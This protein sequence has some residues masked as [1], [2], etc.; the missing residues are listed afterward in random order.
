[1]R[2][3]GSGEVCSDYLSILAEETSREAVVATIG[4]WLHVQGR[5][6]WDALELQAIDAADPA[7]NELAQLLMSAGHPIHRRRHL[8]CWR[9]ELP[10][11]WE[12]YLATL[13]RTRRSMVRKLQRNCFDTG[14]AVVRCACTP[15]E[16]EQ[17]WRILVDLHQR[18]RR[19]L[20]EYGCFATPRF[21]QFLKVAMRRLFDRGLVRLQ[22]VELDGRPAVV[23]ID[24]IG[25]D[26]L[27]LYQSGIEPD[28]ANERPGWLGTMA[29]LRAGAEAG[30]G[31]YD[32]LRGD[33]PYKAHWR[34]RAVPLVDL[35]IVAAHP[36]SQARHAFWLGLQSAKSVGKRVRNRWR[37][38]PEISSGE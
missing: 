28:L 19:T 27:Y 3:L 10:V 14:R 33:E 6:E 36:L 29:T 37:H 1:V 5:H 16:F 31:Y 32:F 8:N 15:E 24:L 7:A 17:G 9:L 11:N 34:A 38:I 21:E 30:F 26:T 35:R 25:G 4:H 22:W 20:G 13:S 18:R 2:F 12:S 23:E